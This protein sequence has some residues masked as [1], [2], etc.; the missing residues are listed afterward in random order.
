[1]TF[2]KQVAK[3][4]LATV[5]IAAKH[6]SFNRIRQV[7]P[8]CSPCTWL[9]FVPRTRNRFADRRFTAAGPRL[10]NDLPPRLRRPDLTFPVFKQ[11]LK[12]NLF[13]HGYSRDRRGA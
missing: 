4:M 1:M 12:T 5:R 10:W 11:K 9:L 2:N 13:G 6:G 8:I 7:A 3:V